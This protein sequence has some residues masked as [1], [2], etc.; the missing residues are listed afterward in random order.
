MLK[1]NLG[2]VKGIT[3]PMESLKNWTNGK[4]ASLVFWVQKGHHWFSFLNFPLVQFSP[5]PILGSVSTFKTF[6]HGQLCMVT[7]LHLDTR[8]LN[9]P[10]LQ[11]SELSFGSVFP[12]TH[13][14]FRFNIYNIYAWTFMCGDF[15]APRYQRCKFSVDSVFRTFLWFSFPCFNI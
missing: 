7:F 6:M 5:S 4:F 1:R 14:R 11:F 8:D 13:P 2:W 15:S 3:K 12:V 9:F 10:L